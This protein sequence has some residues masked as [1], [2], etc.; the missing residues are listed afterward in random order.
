MVALAT[1][2]DLAVYTQL[3]IDDSDASAL[4]LLDMAS[5]QVRDYLQQQ[6]D[7]VV[8]DVVTLDPVLTS[9]TALVILPEMPVSS[10][11]LVEY[12]LD[13]G[14]T[15]A[16][17]QKNSY[18]TPGDYIVSREQG[19]V[20]SVMFPSIT[21]PRDPDSWR[22]TYTHGFQVLPNT[23]KMIV[24]EQAGQQYAT[25]VG[26]DQERT[27]MRQVKYAPRPLSEVQM[28]ALSRYKY[29]RVA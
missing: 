11:S 20:Q 1:P 21:W 24:L 9:T 18:N 5:D 2:S 8:D 27:G 28:K 22:I 16:T 4:A 26:I 10:V 19:I 15:W 3:P 25:P 14:T 13:G 6:I 7:Y 29:P 17:A 12:S 23:I